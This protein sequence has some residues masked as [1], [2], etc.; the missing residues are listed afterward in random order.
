MRSKQW[1]S[2]LARCTL[3]ERFGLTTNPYKVAVRME[4]DQVAWMKL[5]ELQS[6]L[7][8][9]FG[10]GPSPDNWRHLQSR[11][12]RTEQKVADLGMGSF[13]SN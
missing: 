2:A 9:Q 8:W 13:G 3:Y 12:V 7:G 4:S 1:E 6:C 5:F 11:L 10:D